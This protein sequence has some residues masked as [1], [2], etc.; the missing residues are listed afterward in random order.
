VFKVERV[1]SS[2]SDATARLGP[3]YEVRPPLLD[4]ATGAA[5]YAAKRAGMPLDRAAV[6]RLGASVRLFDQN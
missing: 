6:L 1:L 2:F 5:L 4:P 3:A